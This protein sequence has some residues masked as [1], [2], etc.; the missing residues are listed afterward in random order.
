MRAAALIALALFAAPAGAGALEGFDTCFARAIAHF[1]MEAARLGTAGLVEDFELVT[2]D[3]VHHCG[4]LAI[5]ACDRG[6]EPQ[7]CQRRLAAAQLALRD[8]VLAGLPAPEDVTAAAPFGAALYPRLWAV[9]RGA[10]AG[11][12]C[13][14]AEDP[15]AAWCETHEARLQLTE[16][17]AAWQVARLIGMAAPAVALGS[18]DS[19]MP[20][21][22][23]PRPGREEDE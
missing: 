16:A 14:G 10:S 18:V 11:D 23:V 15:V 2:R 4:S 22:P 13:A 8:R 7:A 21:E 6:P 12:D 5:V 9:A 17:V 3:R 1:E 19:A 20:F